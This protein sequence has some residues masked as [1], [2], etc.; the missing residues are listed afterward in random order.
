MKK[1]F[2]TL[3]IA[4]LSI[5]AFSMD[6]TSISKEIKL[7]NA[8]ENDVFINEDNESEANQMFFLAMITETGNYTSSCG[9]KWHYT[10]TYSDSGSGVDQSM[11]RFAH[12]SNLMD[13][14]NA[15][16]GTDKTKVE[17]QY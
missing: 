7:P 12:L 4:A 14:S 15:A 2:L 6:S 3:F 1:I 5:S 8:T 10:I 17:I 9:V 11:S 16:C 13:A